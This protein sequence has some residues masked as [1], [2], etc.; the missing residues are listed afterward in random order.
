MEQGAARHVGVWLQR[1]QCRL[2]EVIERHKIFQ[3]SCH[4]GAVVAPGQHCGEFTN[5]IDAGAVSEAL[6]PAIP[7]PSGSESSSKP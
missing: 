6:T 2:A 3:R 5:W 1:V 7:T 4:F